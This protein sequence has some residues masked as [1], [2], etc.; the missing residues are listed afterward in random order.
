MNQAD[1]ASI[2]NGISPKN[3]PPLTRISIPSVVK[4]LIAIK[5]VINATRETEMILMIGLIFAE[6]KGIVIMPDNKII[7]YTLK[8]RTIRFSPSS[9]IIY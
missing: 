1:R 6:T 2:L 4:P 8:R 7:M 3:D 9:T 5:L